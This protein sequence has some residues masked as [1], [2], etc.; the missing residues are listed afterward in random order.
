MFEILPSRRNAETVAMILAF[1]E[2]KGFISSIDAAYVCGRRGYGTPRLVSVWLVRHL[3]VLPTWTAT[4]KIVCD[5]P[6]VMA[7]CGCADQ[8]EVH[9]PEAMYRFLKKLRANPEWLNALIQALQAAI[10]EL[11]PN[12]GRTLAG[13]GTD[14]EAYANGQKYVKRG[15]PLRTRFSDPDASWGHRGSISTRKGGGFYGYKPHGLVCCD[16]SFP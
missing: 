8:G 5:N 9:S 14:L 13:D 6:R 12:F 16:E 2:I 1:P 10:R 4:V 7:V 3:Y 15:G 11:R